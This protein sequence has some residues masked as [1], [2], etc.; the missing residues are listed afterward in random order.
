MISFCSLLI[1][2]D[3]FHRQAKKEQARNTGLKSTLT[4]VKREIGSPGL[5]RTGGRPI[6]S[7]M[8]YR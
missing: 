2:H 3:L 5:I 7:R 1:D 6:N 8:L 4:G